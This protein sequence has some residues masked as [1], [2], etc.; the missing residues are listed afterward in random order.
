MRI[1]LTQQALDVMRAKIAHNR[2]EG[3][4]RWRW[5]DSDVEALLDYIDRLRK[6]LGESQSA[7]A[8]D[9][10]ASSTGKPTP[11]DKGI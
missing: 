1:D 10:H 11:R 6:R 4:I 3:E 7:D 8:V 9:P 5:F 2:E